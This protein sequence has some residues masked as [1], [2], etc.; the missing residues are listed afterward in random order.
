[1]GPTLC[2]VRTSRRCSSFWQRKLSYH[3]LGP[4]PC[5]SLKAS[6][7]YTFYI[8]K[9][10]YYWHGS[11]VLVNILSPREVI[12]AL[13]T[14][15]LGKYHRLDSDRVRRHAAEMSE[16]AKFVGC[17]GF[18]RLVAD[19]PHGES[20]YGRR[21]QYVQLVVVSSDGVILVRFCTHVHFGGLVAWT[22]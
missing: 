12:E 16:D 9:R 3:I 2:E 21:E 17:E 20:W 13:Y 15:S 7:W 6:L 5:S 8:H 1:M 14:P 18:E 4:L 22:T 19:G 11:L 10:Y